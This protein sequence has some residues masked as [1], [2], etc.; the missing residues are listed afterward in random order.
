[1]GFVALM[2]ASA[3]GLMLFLVVLPWV[4]HSWKRRLCFLVT[5][6]TV[7]RFGLDAEWRVLLVRHPLE[8]GL[9]FLEAGLGLFVV[10]L[11]SHWY[12]NGS[13]EKLEID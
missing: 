3:L 10:L 6:V 1:M 2:V 8:L 4:S 9:W 7:V 13:V 12:A 5:L 11:F